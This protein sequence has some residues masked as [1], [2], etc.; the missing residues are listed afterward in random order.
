MNNL[1]EQ[2]D[3]KGSDTHTGPKPAAE[4]NKGAA[5]FI[6]MEGTPDPK[7]QNDDDGKN[8]TPDNAVKEPLTPVPA[9]DEINPPLSATLGGDDVVLPLK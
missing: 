4:T 2:I 9:E 6:K 7:P 8:K 1:N 5:T 3:K